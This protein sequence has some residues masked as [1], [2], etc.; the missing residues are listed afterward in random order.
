[1]QN[2]SNA[3]HNRVQQY[4]LSAIRAGLTVHGFSIEGRKISVYTQPV[5]AVASEEDEGT[6]WLRENV[7]IRR[8]SK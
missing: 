1:M 3:Q 8:R 7:Q 2:G 5:N 6:R 4:V